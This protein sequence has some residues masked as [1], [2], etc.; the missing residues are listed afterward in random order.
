MTK[1]EV[2]KTYDTKGPYSDWW[3]SYTVVKRTKCTVTLLDEFYGIEK[4]RK[5]KE[6]NGS[7]IVYPEGK[8]SMC[9]TLSAERD[10]NRKERET[11]RKAQA[12]LPDNVISFDEWKSRKA[13]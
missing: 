1:F 11:Q 6:Y 12:A 2:G 8:Y 5:I 10:E 9:P 4:R 7:E 3:Y 13:V